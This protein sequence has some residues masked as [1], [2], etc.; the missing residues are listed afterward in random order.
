MIP[1]LL[2]AR[3]GVKLLA[4]VVNQRP[5]GHVLFF[6][7]FCCFLSHTRAL[8]GGF[9]QSLKLQLLHVPW[10]QGVY[11]LL[12]VFIRMFASSQLPQEN[13]VLVT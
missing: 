4:R 11:Y 6:S 10:K 3:E 7:E 8:E 13:F 1:G 12:I 2:S 5:W 9:A